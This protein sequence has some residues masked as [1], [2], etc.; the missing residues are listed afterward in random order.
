MGKTNSQLQR[1]NAFERA[2]EA[3]LALGVSWWQ[4]VL[5]TLGKSDLNLEVSE[6]EFILLAEGSS[7]G[8]QVLER[9]T[10]VERKKGKRKPRSWTITRPIPYR[11]STLPL[12]MLEGIARDIYNE[13]EALWREANIENLV[14]VAQSFDIGEALADA[15]ECLG[16][17]ASDDELQH[18]AE[19]LRYPAEL[20]EGGEAAE[21]FFDESVSRG[22][23]VEAEDGTVTFVE[24]SL[25][26]GSQPFGANEW[27]HYSADEV[28]ELD[29]PESD[30]AYSF[31]VVRLCEAIRADEKNAIQLAIQLGAVTREWE[32]WRENEEFLQKGRELFAAQQERARTNRRKAWM[33]RVDDDFRN[34]RIAP[35]AS[36]Y[37]QRLHRDRTLDLPSVD[38]IKNYISSLRR[39]EHETS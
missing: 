16:P 28:A 20:V 33:D 19:Q 10:I 4:V 29:G 31:R 17:D 18:F 9:R 11:F 37:A 7:L 36:A 26:P 14:R 27:D 1:K 5:E 30:W 35:T 39:S 38:R 12:D 24:A 6:P 22:D 34:G 8:P 15:R 25:P 13:S 21:R 2:D 23:V 32:I 3:A